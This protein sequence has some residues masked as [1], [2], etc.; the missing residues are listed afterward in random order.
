LGEYKGK[1]RVLGKLM[2]ILVVQESDWIEKG[3]HQSHHL[4]ERLSKRGHEVR[5]IDYEIL[6]RSHKDGNLISKRQVFKNIWKA[7]KGGNVT[8]IRPPIMKLPLMDYLSLLYT[9]GK[10][11][12]R[13]LNEFSPDV[14]VGFGIL[15]AMLAIK[16]TGEVPFVYYLIDS[17][18]KLIPQKALQP[19]GEYIESRTLRNAD[20][21]IV[22]NE[23]LKE[24]AI[25][26]GANPEKT[27]VIKAG[28]D[29]ERFN[30]S[31]NGDNIRAQYRIEKDDVVLF[32]MGWLYHFSGL[33]EV[34]MELNKNKI[35]TIKLLIVGDGDA[36]NDLQEIKVR[37]NLND[38]V[39]LT[40]KQP[41]E[42]IPEFISAA[43]ICLLPAYPN[44]KIMQDIVPIKMYEYM[45]MEK[46]VISTKLPGIMKEFGEDNGVVYVG[47][48]EE[49]V[50]KAIELVQNG[51]VKSLGIKTRKFVE[52]YSWDNVVDEFERVLREIIYDE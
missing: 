9:H 31:I 40:G 49:V 12:K 8:V 15:N 37:Y 38:R 27:Y 18:H 16:L 26:M 34:A 17:L 42:K 13:Q 29:F 25:K 50:D 35:D 21:V 43:D 51:T 3:P 23:K 5:V 7:I 11:I 44:E 20:R 36:L 47:R 24:Y 6:W 52:R 45:A 4:M 10:E 41:Y 48:P 39:I 33:K 28:L 46:P 19:L 22:I 14:I 1:R 2:K 30:P 32:F